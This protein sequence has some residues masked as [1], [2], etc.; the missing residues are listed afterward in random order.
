MWRTGHQSR[1]L[2]R[3]YFLG[4]CALR[5]YHTEPPPSIVNEMRTLPTRRPRGFVQ[6]IQSRYLAR[7]SATEG[8]RA[9]TAAVVDR[10]LPVG[11]VRGEQTTIQSAH[12]NCPRPF[13]NCLMAQ[14][15][16]IYILIYCGR[17]KSSIRRFGGCVTCF[18]NFVYEHVS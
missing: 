17:K 13:V 11:R 14:I 12:R 8:E 15:L 4:W 2:E 5:K 16:R 18:F 1:K 3:C 6:Y 9:P 7:P 10:T